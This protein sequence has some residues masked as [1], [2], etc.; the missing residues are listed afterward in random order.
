MFVITGIN[1]CKKDELT[2]NTYGIDPDSQRSLLNRA[3]RIDGKLEEG[4]MPSA[5]GN[6]NLLIVNYPNAVEVSAGVYLYI[7]FSTNNNANICKL[8]LQ[9]A[10]A[11]SY[12]D[13]RLKIDSSSNDPYIEVFIPNFVQDG[14]FNLRFAIGDCNGNISGVVIVNTV[15]TPPLGCGG[16]SSGSVGITVNHYR[17]GDNSGLVTV[18][19]D[20]YSIK[21]RIDIRYNNQWIASSGTVLGSNAIGPN[22]SLD[23]FVSGTHTIQFNYNPSN[24]RD[25]Y[26]Y[27]TGCDSGTAW[28]VT[29]DCP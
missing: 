11:D 10:D 28:D 26:I 23:G 22:C 5:T 27:V 21:D 17:L 18:T 9:V 4:S 3:L 20:M 19:Y 13:V 6:G 14:D 29:V 16:S 2:N 25:V 8:Y 15:V 24:G 7:P 12:W 1:S